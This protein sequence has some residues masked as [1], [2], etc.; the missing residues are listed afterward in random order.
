MVIDEVIEYYGSKVGAAR[1]I[2]IAPPN[3]SMWIRKGYIPIVSQLK[4]EKNSAGILK[5][6]VDPSIRQGGIG[7]ASGSPVGIYL[8]CGINGKMKIRSINMHS[9][10]ICIVCESPTDS[11]KPVSFR[12]DAKCREK[13]D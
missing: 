8:D 10:H 3:I 12:M 6:D 7:S 2:G 1:A 11:G 9:T 5:A 4:F 13:E